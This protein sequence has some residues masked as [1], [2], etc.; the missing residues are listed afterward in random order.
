MQ[1]PET[2]REWCQWYLLLSSIHRD[3]DILLSLHAGHHCRQ[4]KLSLPFNYVLSTAL[5]DQP[6]LVKA[7]LLHS[8]KRRSVTKPDPYPSP[9][10]KRPPKKK[11]K[12]ATPLSAAFADWLRSV[13]ASLR[14]GSLASTP[15]PEL[16]FR[17][18]RL[19]HPTTPTTKAQARKRETAPPSLQQQQD[20][21]LD[22]NR[23]A[24]T[25]TS[26]TRPQK[27]A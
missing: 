25:P 26:P 2:T 5:A 12:T 20:F 6:N 17:N 27:I 21:V 13:S 19:G 22:C 24:Q 3:T 8:N 11:E 15:D 4:M 16:I 1:E 14:L 23:A 9:P 10:S 18:G 7:T